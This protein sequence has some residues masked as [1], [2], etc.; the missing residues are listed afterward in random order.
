MRST[1]RV[2]ALSIVV[3]IGA[4][5]GGILTVGAAE[6]AAP[7]QT[8]SAAVESAPPRSAPAGVLEEIVITAQRRAENLQDVP[9]SVTALSATALAN[10]GIRNADDI[11]TVVPS[12]EMNRGTGPVLIFLR[13][14][15]N[16][17]AAAGIENSTATYVDGIYYARVPPALF[18]LNN[19][20][21]IEVL[22]GP[23]GTLFGRNATGGLVQIITR[24]PQQTPEFEG[25]IGFANYATVSG[26]AYVTGGIAPGVAADFAVQ[27]KDQNQGWGRN[28]TTG[29]EAHLGHDFAARTKLVADLSD[30]TRLTFSADYFN[31]HN[32]DL[33]AASD[34]YRGTTQGSYLPNPPQ[35]YGP[36]PGFYDVRNGLNNLE[37]EQGYG[38]SIRLDQKLSFANFVSLTSYH[39]ERIN[40]NPYDVDYLPDNYFFAVLSEPATQ[41]SQEFQLLSKDDSPFK[42]IVGA[43][44]F[45]S[46]DGYDPG[47]LGGRQFGG[48][49]LGFTSKQKIDSYA[50]YAQST[51]EVLP[52]T[53]LTG[54]VR[55]TADKIG[56]RGTL[57][58]ELP[59][60][61]VLAPAAPPVD[62]SSRVSKVTW[63]FALDHKFTHD[64]MGFMSVSRGFQSG[65]YQTLPA[66][67]NIAKPEV[68][69]AYE[70]GF[71]MDLFDHQFRLNPSVFYYNIKELQVEIL[72]G[73]AV[74]FV[75]AG[76][77]HVKGIDADFELVATDKLTF[78]GG[79]AYIDGKYTNFVGAPDTPPNPGP[80]GGNLGVVPSDA[81]GQQMERSPK[82]TGNLNAVYTVPAT[83]GIW[84]F[85]GGVYYNSGFYWVP[86][87][88][89]KQDAY[90]LLDAQVRYAFWHD[91]YSV[92][93]WGK[94]LADKK[95]YSTAYAQG[96]PYGYPGV[97]APPRTYGVNFSVK[98]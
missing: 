7:A 83:S 72:N 4:F 59:D 94:N 41:A 79:A 86:T 5:S 84:T 92:Q 95:Y 77:A 65:V 55:Y 58:A 74:L 14:V 67:A 24:T 10:A 64:T 56:I 82:F 8:D 53:N 68:L 93:L 78:R 31:T 9:V 37:V 2:K 12:L 19:I 20:D 42:W 39:H 44:Y 91:H 54:G 45:N 16:S 46:K 60:G 15:G 11:G 52:D 75:N 22:K 87:H 63:K 38:V 66:S 3:G 57:N 40:F 97:P 70:I 61:T 62:A 1:N 35:I 32:K 81:S 34:P 71:K 50:G 28:V 47:V 89:I 73:P 43:F 88:R 17:D 76:G 90:A 51:V 6:Q 80:N 48:I 85:V 26:S 36:L 49:Q 13:G 21:R 29:R 27:F 25:T 98:Y 23:Q 18:E 69:D 30:Q 33:S 96:G